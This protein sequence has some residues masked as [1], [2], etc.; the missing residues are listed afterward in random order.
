MSVDDIV[1]LKTI[2]G[3]MKGED[4]LAFIKDDLAP[5][6]QSTVNYDLNIRYCSFHFAVGKMKTQKPY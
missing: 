6:A 5:T 1:C 3:S 4:F 2:H